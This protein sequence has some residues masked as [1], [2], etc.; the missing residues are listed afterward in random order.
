MSLEI[1]IKKKQKNKEEA[2]DKGK[3]YL[4]PIATS[5]KSVTQNTKKAKEPTQSITPQKLATLKTSAMI[6]FI[7]QSEELEK[8][9]Q[10]VKTI[11]HWGYAQEHNHKETVALQERTLWLRLE[12]IQWM[13]NKDMN[14]REMS[15]WESR[16]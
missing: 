2:Q 3:I 8:I 1:T 9:Q 15:K 7:D 4:P 10:T 16:V 11:Y 5:P 12:L 14:K 6:R 13:N